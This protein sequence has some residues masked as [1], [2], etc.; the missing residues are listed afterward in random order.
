LRIGS[1]GRISHYRLVPKNGRNQKRGTRRNGV[2]R[3]HLMH[4][5]C[6]YLQHGKLDEQNKSVATIAL[7]R[8]RSGSEI[9]SQIKSTERRKKKKKGNVTRDDRDRSVS[10]LYNFQE[11]EREEHR[12]EER[13]LHVRGKTRTKTKKKKKKKRKKRYNETTIRFQTRA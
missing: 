2:R 4:D 3:C 1:R 6:G 8:P 7:F 12:D 10:Y 5:R 11:E 13:S 9:P